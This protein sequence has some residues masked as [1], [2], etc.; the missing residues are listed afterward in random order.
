MPLPACDRTRGRSPVRPEPAWVAPNAALVGSVDLAEASSV[1][2]GAVLRGLVDGDILW[3]REPDGSLVNTF[4]QDT[5]GDRLSTH[6][7]DA[8]G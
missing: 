6:G 2:T 5:P 8:A 7:M 4:S 3:R 1:F